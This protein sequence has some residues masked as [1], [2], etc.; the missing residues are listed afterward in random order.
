[1]SR[2][3]HP[4]A[5]E[6]VS[7]GPS[8][9]LMVVLGAGGFRDETLGLSGAVDYGDEHFTCFQF[10]YDWRR[11]TVENVERL[12]RF[13]LEK[14]AYVEGELEKRYGLHDQEIK[15]NLVTHSAGGPL[16]RYYLRYGAADLPEDGSLPEISWEG[17]RWVER[18]VFIGPPNAGS[19]K[20]FRQLVR[21]RKL[22]PFYPTV[23]PA[24]IGTAPFGYQSLPRGRHGVLVDAADPST[25]LDVLDPELWETMGWGLAS[26]EQDEVLRWL[27][28]RGDLGGTP[29]RAVLPCCPGLELK[30]RSGTPSP[31]FG[32]QPPTARG[33]GTRRRWI[34]SASW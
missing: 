28:P 30:T 8:H 26:P 23:P 13:I 24:V 10:D 20:M 19:L 14:K 21:G 4:W 12:H 31:A 15:F 1:M 27:L 22:G 32:P 18:A 33:P 2:E 11:D 16:A 29:R 5:A 3:R 25:R 17:S 6:L 7:S 34:W 9:D